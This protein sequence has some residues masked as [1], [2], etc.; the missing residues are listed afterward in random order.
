MVVNNRV[1]PKNVDD[2]GNEGEIRKLYKRTTLYIRSLFTISRLL[3]SYSLLQHKL[4]LRIE[5]ATEETLNSGALSESL[6]TSDEGEGDNKTFEV[7]NSTSLSLLQ[8]T[9]GD[10]EIGVQFK[11]LPGKFYTIV[12]SPAIRVPQQVIKAKD[13]QINSSPAGIGSGDWI[14][15][16]QQNMYPLK[17]QNSATTGQV[18][19]LTTAHKPGGSSLATGT[20]LKTQP[21]SLTD[22]IKLFEKPPPQELVSTASISMAPAQLIEKLE[23]GRS[24]K[25]LFD[26]WL[27]ELEI[28][29]KSLISGGFDLIN[30]ME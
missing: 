7:V 21:T 24:K 8:T 11:K 16:T 20:N 2:D 17:K 4:P 6:I 5:I 10:L 27:E 9:H 26:R 23:T 14:D 13:I 18:K 3:P 15:M 19:I 28:E 1:S 25:V 12:R 30:N 22:F 29:H